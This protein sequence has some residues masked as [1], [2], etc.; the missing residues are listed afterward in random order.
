MSAK[1]REPTAYL[2][3]ETTQ[4][5]I[6]EFIKQLEDQFQ[7]NKNA[8]LISAQGEEVE[9]PATLIDI[10]RQVGEALANGRG[11][12]VIPQESKL[13]TQTAADFLGISRPTLVKLLERGQIPFEKVGRHRRVTLR[14]L[15]QYR[16][17]FRAQRRVALR[18]LARAGQEAGLLEVTA[19][20]M[21]EES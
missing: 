16:D 6:S 11:V 21:K 2:P 14:D 7:T 5:E 10:L 3:D 13:T 1:S 9:L 15:L 4:S 17:R 20:E 19:S 18:R 12:S 8:K